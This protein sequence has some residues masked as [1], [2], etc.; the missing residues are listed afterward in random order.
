MAQPAPDFAEQTEHLRQID[1]RLA[2]LY[3]RPAWKSH[4]PPLDELIATILSQHTSDINTARAFAALRNRYPNWQAVIDAQ[5]AD[6]AG[7]IRSGGLSSVKA[8]RIQRVL[9]AVVAETGEAS[10]DWLGNLTLDEARTWLRALPGVGPKTAACVLLFSLGL[11]AMPVDTHVH[12]VS[13]RLG[14]IPTR[15][16]ADA[17]H[18][19]LDRL[20]GGDRDAVYA[21]HLNVIRHGRE[22]CKA[23]APSCTRC[24]LADVCPSAPIEPSRTAISGAQH[25]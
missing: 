18:E 7:A 22:T 3:G 2:R 9:R 6:V 1:T 14:L 5:P 12:R 25:P 13:R 10:L 20:I 17:A 19:A 4:G 8:P 16:S 23:R 11:P 24:V 21:W 15:M